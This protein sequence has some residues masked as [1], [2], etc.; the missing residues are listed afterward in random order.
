M[1]RIDYLGTTY[2]VD[3]GE[4]VLQ[5][6]L[7]QGANARYSCGKGSCRACML[8]L[9]DGEVR[10][11]SPPPVKVEQSG[12][13]LPCI[14]SPVGDIVLAEPDP[15]AL[16]QDAE[17]VDLR[18]LGADMLEVSIAPLSDFEFQPGQHID[19]IRP[20][21]VSRPYSLASSPQDDY[22]FRIHVRRID[23]G[24]MSGWLFNDAKAGDRVTF[25]GSFGDCC[26]AATMQQRP[27]LLLSTGSGGGAMLALA[28]AALEAGHGAQVRMFHGVR[29][30]RDRFLDEEMARLA[31]RFPQF[32]AVTCVT[33][34]PAEAG[35][36]AG[37][38]VE[39]ACA[40]GSMAAGTELFLCGNPAMVEQG[41]VAAIAA[42]IARDC[43]HAD[44]FTFS[45]DAMPRDRE[46]MAAFKPDPALWTALED[47]AL[48]KRVLTE[49]YDEVF[50]DAR[51]APFFH[52]FTKEFVA[53]KQYSFLSDLISG[54]R[55]FFGLNP[56]NSHHWM[57]ISDELFDY[58]EGLFERVMRRHLHDEAM[59][60]RFMAIHELFRAEIVKAAPRGIITDGVEQPFKTHTVEVLDM[61]MVCDKCADEIPAGQPTRYHHRAGT[62]HCASCAG[63][64]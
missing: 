23:D 53:G 4:S 29:Y 15:L 49:F 22:F 39:A 45:G 37:R 42:G 28:R 57:V 30:N 64:A 31:A 40:E 41:R 24:D 54:G 48:L 51:L 52:G 38:V 3:A 5:A 34:E 32:Q 55:S 12:H 35:A 61:D 18:P 46:K 13:V 14:C 21:G 62:L 60:N 44:P 9:V 8:Q 58:R 10:Y 27:L 11:S 16:V 59:L 7:R 2:A 1:S 25:R 43:I 19:L 47:G 36:M 33:R 26:Y 6:L 20:D 56:H 50:E 17:I 63:I